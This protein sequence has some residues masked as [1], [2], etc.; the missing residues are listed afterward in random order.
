[1][2]I[3]IDG[4]ACPSKEAIKKVAIKHHLETIVYVDTAHVMNDEY[5]IIKIISQGADAVDMAIANDIEK[6][7]ILIT[8]DYGLASLTLLSCYA[9]INPKGFRYT[10]DNIDS[11]LM[12]RHLSAK[13]RRS[14][15]KNHTKHKKRTNNDEIALINILEEV[16]KSST[17]KS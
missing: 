5:F 10:L 11:M 4:D 1:M 3:I 7:D 16:I 12:Q 6:D 15:S 8:Q 13:A 9:V 2:R 17:Y 14:G